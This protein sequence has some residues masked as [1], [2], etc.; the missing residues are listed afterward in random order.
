VL[1]F[2]VALV[3]SWRRR[4]PAGDDPWGGNSL[5]WATSSPPPEH[6]F[7]RVPPVRSIRP[8]HDLRAGADGGSA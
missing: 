4:E 1:V 2:V 3:V 5:E 8:A 6:N 7:E